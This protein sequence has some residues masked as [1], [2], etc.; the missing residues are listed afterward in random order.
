[1]KARFALVGLSLL[2]LGVAWTAQTPEGFKPGKLPKE[3]VAALQPGWILRFYDASGTKLLDTRPARVAALHVPEGTAPSPALPSGLFVAK[4]TGYFKIP[5]RNEYHFHLFA[6]GAAALRVNGK[7]TLIVTDGTTQTKD[8]VELARGYNLLELTLTAPAKGDATVRLS[9]SGEDFIVE[10]VPPDSMFARGDD[11]DLS[12]GQ[13]WREGRFHFTQHHCAE[14]HALPGGLARKDAAMP[15]IAHRPPSL[16]GAGDRFQRDWLARWILNPRVLR[17][18]ATMPA[19]LHGPD[20]EQQAADIAAYV[21]TLTRMPAEHKP[22]NAQLGE[23]LYAN[24]GCV[25]CHTFDDPLKQESFNRYPL[26][27]IAAKYREPELTQFLMAPHRHYPWTRMPDFKFKA[28]EAAALAAYLFLEAKGK[29]EALPALA[30]A[31]AQRGEQLFQ[32]T[33]CAN[34]HS[35]GG[36]DPHLAKLLPAPTLLERGCLATTPEARGKAPDYGFKTLKLAGLV[37][38]LKERS[39]TLARDTALEFAARQANNLKCHACHRR[40]GRSS[41]W[42]QALE[43]DGILPEI[44]P[45]LTWSGEK[46]KPEWIEKLLKGEHDHRARPWLKARMPAFHA[47][48]ESLAVGLAHEHG[49]G[50]AEDDAPPHDAKLAALG[51]KLLPQVG[52][53]NCVQCHGVG[54]QKAVAPFEAPGINLLDAAQRLRYRYYPRWMLD[55]PRVDIATKMPKLSMDGKTTGIKD[56]L[57]G[58]ARKQFDALWHY[59]QTLK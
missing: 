58:D 17:P 15:E 18:R 53:F 6:R 31:D 1:M 16:E 59:I 44:L 19:V 7:E 23:K 9:W 10:P 47:R 2:F 36:N 51:A 40:D 50:A 8:V 25:A 14:C 45:L 52:G 43:E 54:E 5:L 33:G 39:S 34:C 48:A 26:T 55:P 37:D 35:R 28:E 20:A 22:G 11:A 12:K 38:F 4:L 29:T 3:E 30:K 24:L 49:F 42:I 56:T 57:D 27:Y 41:L 13:R 46:L 21:A 32:S